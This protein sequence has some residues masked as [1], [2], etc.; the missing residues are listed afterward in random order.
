M[1]RK[2]LSISGLA[3][4]RAEPDDGEKVII[5]PVEGKG[6]WGPIFGYVSLR[7]DMNNSLWC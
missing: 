6:L 3:V 4:F 5:I 2:K 1:S 7:S